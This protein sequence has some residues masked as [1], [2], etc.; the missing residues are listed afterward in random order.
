MSVP[1][2]FGLVVGRCPGAVAVV[3]G[4]VELSYAELDARSD[5]VAGFLVGCGVGVGDVVGLALPGSV[6]LVVAMLGVLKVGA[7][8]LPLD[9]EYPV[10]RL[11]F[12]V[13]DACPVVVVGVDG[14]GLDGGCWV[15]RW[16]GCRRCCRGVRVLVL[17]RVRVLGLVGV[18]CRGVMRR[19]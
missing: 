17:V 3:D 19:M 9:P 2:L 8:Y 18:W 11:V 13:G 12:M 5:V 4:V 10:G 15:F 7:A 1:E 6:G 16:W 14:W